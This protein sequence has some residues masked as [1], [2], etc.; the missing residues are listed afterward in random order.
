MSS[1]PRT[2]YLAMIVIL[3]IVVAG[4]FGCSRSV[5]GAARLF[6]VKLVGDKNWGLMDAS[7]NIVVPSDFKNRPSVVAE[8]MFFVQDKNGEY[9]YY[10]ATRKYKKIAGGFLD[11]SSFSEG[12]AAVV[13]GKADNPRIQYIDK[14]GKLK[15]DV[16]SIKG[17]KILAASRFNEG[18]A[19]V[20]NED[21]KYGYINKKGDL[22]IDFKYRTAGLFWEGL[23]RVI[24]A[25]D[26]E[27]REGFI[28]K[29][30][31]VVIPFKADRDYQYFV[32]GYCV[33]EDDESNCGTID[34]KGNVVIKPTETTYHLN[35]FFGGC[36]AF[37]NGD[38]WGLMNP[39]GDQIVRPKYD[40]LVVYPAG[41]MAVKDDKCGVISQ[42]GKDILP[43]DY[44]AAVPLAPGKFLV[45][46]SKNLL[47]VDAKGKSI[48]KN[49]F[50]D[51]GLDGL[52]GVH[53]YDSSV[54]WTPRIEYD[55]FF[56]W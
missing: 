55:D 48:G 5:K 12:L 52:W 30:G 38:D 10:T 13:A 34:K 6:P 3:L 33:F 49:E 4:F 53:A 19:F 15:L 8:G 21:G 39:R 18:L 26:D 56:D 42:S 45:R 46:E 40:Y 47:I 1:A 29:K 27:Y 54:S 20:R 25:D 41:V 7:G 14:K 44:K 11:A 43:F 28:N 36:A 32:N 9:D 16:K 23:A 22:V 37:G 31:E 24:Q 51:I 2:K 50:E 35:S 17:K